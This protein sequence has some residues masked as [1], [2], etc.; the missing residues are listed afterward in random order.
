MSEYDSEV[1]GVMAGRPPSSYGSMHS[2]DEEEEDEDDFE[3]PVKHAETKVSLYRSGSPE[4]AITG[5]THTNQS[6]V[7]QDGLYLRQQSIVH[8]EPSHSRHEEPMTLEQSEVQ[9]EWTDR[10]L[11]EDP[12]DQEMREPNLPD[13]PS[14]SPAMEEQGTEPVYDFDEIVVHYEE[15]KDPPPPPP[16]GAGLQFRHTHTSLTLRHVLMAMVRS[17]SQLHP[18]EMSFYKRCLSSNYKFKKN[19]PVIADL[20]DPLDV[21]D[22][23]IEICKLGEA[24]HLTVRTLQNI[25][26]KELSETLRKTCRRALLRYDLKIAYDRRYYNLYEGRCRPG[27][28]RYISDVYVEPVTVIRGSRDPINPENEVQRIPYTIEE[29]A[30]RAADIFRPLP[31]DHKPIR[32]VMMTGIPAC[33]VTV[34]VNKFL[35]DWME[36]KNNQDFQLVFPMPAKELHLEKGRDLSFLETLSNYFAEAE[37][38][39]FLEK[40]DCLSL[41]IIDGIEVCRHKLDF[42]NNEIVTSARQK[43]PLDAILTSL[44]K[45]TLLPNACVWLTSHVSAAYKIPSNLIDRFVELRG[46]TDEA[47]KE[48]FT[49]RTTE[50][51]LGIK[52]YNH[53]KRS[54]ALEI[55]CHLPLFSWMVAFIFERAF[56]DPDYGKHPPGITAFYSQYIVVQMNRAFEKFRGC[57]VEDQKWRDVDKTFLE[58]M[59]K[60]AYR[61]ILEGRDWFKVAD[62]KNVS[63][64]YEDLRSREELTTEVKRA[65]EDVETWVF[66]FVHV[67]I[68]EYMAAMYVYVAFRKHAKNVFIS[69][70]MSWLQGTASKDRPMIEMYRPAIDRML[71]SPNGHLDMFLRFLIGLVTPGTEDNLRGYLLNHYHPKAKGTE[72]VVKYINKK[73]RENIHP[74]RHRNL[75]LCLVELEEGKEER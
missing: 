9:S 55:I 4:T 17:L 22:K 71:A 29:T 31:S 63:L 8:K 26:R 2:D 60:M 25:G 5:R 47:K 75:E 54:K 45:G 28:Q 3:P 46:F 49:K 62:L 35:I 42:E 34:A 52:V 14:E 27:Q 59:G 32:T 36:E 38:I 65:S 18:S 10:A 23:M 12:G 6:S 61:M 16:E 19:S 72:E 40:E 58:M 24:L 74:D 69:S 56:R 50:P 13:Q 51:E 30:I 1:E 11:N 37:E 70:Q 48:Y 20:T 41:F 73:M 64:T 53:M 67:T 21:A 15:P 33:G 68:Q 43:A 44:I 39:G 7:Y 57:N 66:K